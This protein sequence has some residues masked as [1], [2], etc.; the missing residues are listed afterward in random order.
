MSQLLTADDVA[1][2]FKLTRKGVE[3][4]ARRGTIPGRVR[5]GRTVR[6]LQEKIDSWAANG[7]PQENAGDN[8]QRSTAA[9]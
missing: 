5:I 8:Q 9:Q 7:C 3:R 1:T 2:R 6:F 4:M